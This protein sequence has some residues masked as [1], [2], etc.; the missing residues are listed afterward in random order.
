[1]RDCALF[2][3]YKHNPSQISP[4][5]VK[6]RDEIV[7]QFARE[8]NIPIVMLTSGLYVPTCHAKQNKIH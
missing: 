7:F 1:M 5:G 8:Q 4:E 2:T 3:E 6:Q